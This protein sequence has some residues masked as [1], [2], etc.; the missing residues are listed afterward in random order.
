MEELE[1]LLIGQK[2]DIAHLATLLCQQ[3]ITAYFG[4][5]STAELLDYLN[6]IVFKTKNTS[7]HT[8]ILWLDNIKISYFQEI[9]LSFLKQR[10]D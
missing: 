9:F 2:H 7:H 4:K 5:V 10:E 3:D 1:S 6:D 8:H